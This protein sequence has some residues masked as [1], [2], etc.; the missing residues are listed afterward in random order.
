MRHP[1]GRKLLRGGMRFIDPAVANAIDGL[2]DDPR[3]LSSA[4]WFKVSTMRRI[5]RFFLPVIGH[6]MGA[7]RR[8][9][10]YRQQWQRWLEERVVDFA[11]R[12]RRATTLAQRVTLFEDMMYEGLLFCCR[13]FAVDG[14][15][16]GLDESVD[17]DEQATAS[18][19][20]RSTAAA[21][22]YAA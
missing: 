20:P 6:L 10:V 9:D 22:R 1:I 17:S 15:R 21:A 16:H 13:T 3:L 2:W 19:Q 11:E 4:G 12:N 14:W 5:G 7:M 8:P 18:W